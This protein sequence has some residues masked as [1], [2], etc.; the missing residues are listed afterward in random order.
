[1]IEEV[2]IDF[3]KYKKIYVKKT[4][5]YLFVYPIIVVI[6]LVIL[7]R[8]VVKLGFNVFPILLVATCVSGFVFLNIIITWWAFYFG[9]MNTYKS[10]KFV[11]EGDKILFIRLKDRNAI[12][13]GTF[14]YHRIQSV[15]GYTIT[16][17]KI[18]VNGNITKRKVDERYPD[19]EYKERIIDSISVPN[20]FGNVKLLEQAL[21][22]KKQGVV[23]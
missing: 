1:M 12:S 7:G 2:I 5:L 4:V 9:Y 23:K 15:S 20:V 11:I 13:G 16:N 14:Y 21:K 19:N 6:I 17:E 10:T 3:K 22:N 18:I 8:I